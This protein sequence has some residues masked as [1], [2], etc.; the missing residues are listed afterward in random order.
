MKTMT[1][2]KIKFAAGFGALA[3]VAGGAATVAISQTSSAG[4]SSA[5]EIV[6]RSQD[7][8]AA[9][10]SYSDEGTSVATIG[11][12]NVAPHTFTIKLARP[13]LYRIEWSQITGFYNQTGIAWSDGSGDFTKIASTPRTNSNMEMALSSA[14]GVSGGADGS[15]PGT[16][17]KMNW[18]NTLGA[19]MQSATRKPDEK[20]GDVDCYVLSH[21]KDGRTR[22]LW[23]GKQDFLIRQIENDTPAAALKAVL[24]AEAKKHPGMGLPTSVAGDSKSFETHTNIVVNQ[25]NFYRRILPLDCQI[26][27]K[28]HPFDFRESA[29]SIVSQAPGAVLLLFR[30]AAVT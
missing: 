10:S 20:I 5:Q 15:I 2:L 26:L 6:K 22:T 4:S 18:G 3:L 16:F 11:A 7:A 24:E 29:A 13:N 12:N 1:W 30:V 23:I 21:E 8:Y 17:F 28:T 19:S 9:L 14:T 27:T 25:L